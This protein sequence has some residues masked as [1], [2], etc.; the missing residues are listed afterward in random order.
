MRARLSLLSL[1]LCGIAASCSRS[2]RGADAATHRDARAIVMPPS[3]PYAAASGAVAAEHGMVATDAP[4]ATHV[5]ATV[6]RN[7]GN[8]VDAA[9]ATAFALSVVF[10]AAGNLGG[11][12]F[13]VLHMGDGRE[14]ALDFR[15]TAPGAA[16]RNMYVG[17]N[18]HADDRSITGDLAAGVP[19]SV[20]GLWE[21]HE[22]YGSRPWAE[23]LAPAIRLADEGFT[24]DSDFAHAIYSDSVRLARFPGSAALF[25]PDKHVP[26]P[27]ER[28]RNPELAAVL[29][30][31]SANGPK[32]FYEGK[33]AQLIEAEMRRGGGIITQ[34]DLAGYHAR[35]RDPVVFTYRG[36]R[37]LSMPLPSSGGITMALAAHELS[38]Y[39][40]HA[41]GWHSSESLH[42]FAEAMRR[43]FAVRNEMLGDPDFA[44]VPTAELLSQSYAD[45]LAASIAPARATPSSSI[46]VGTGASTEGHQTTHFSVIDG[47]GG[48][49][50]LTTTINGG[51]G[52]GVVVPGTG[53]LLNDEMDDFA[54]EP[55]APNMFGLVQGENNAIAPGKRMLSSMSPTIVLGADGT[56]LL[57]TGASGGPTIISSAFEVM[58]NVVDYDMDIATAVSAPRVHDQHLPDTLFYEAG[59]LPD[60]TLAALRAMGYAMASA[61][62][63]DIGIGA[64]ILR[65]GG[66]V[67]GM[68]DPRVSGLAEGY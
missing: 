67:Y 61:P 11:G 24:V 18:G 41:S 68:A 3:W 32:G 26:R 38:H 27:G 53:V 14:A 36:H 13:I 47:Q 15:E 2:P 46:H 5:G 64:S 37:V 33:T 23:L 45:S 50:A 56:P 58:S 60:S 1:W 57:V 9:V 12:G 66:K 52:A 25:F 4:L 39:D 22:R 16:S 20:D 43:G 8:A 54:T 59:G 63:G 28:W 30:R 10:P 6:L 44:K 35:W 34:R 51:F 49:V 55:G 17:T 42:L 31:I 65:R 7:G 29:R 62:R 21:A 48:A 40:L 19:G